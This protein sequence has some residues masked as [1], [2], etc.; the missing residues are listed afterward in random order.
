M[1]TL[2]C[3]RRNGGSGGEL[4]VMKVKEREGWW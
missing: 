2:I 1:F 3:W 4:V